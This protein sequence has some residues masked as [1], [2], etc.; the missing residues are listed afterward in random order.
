MYGLI[1]LKHH[2]IGKQGRHL[3]FSFQGKAKTQNDD[4]YTS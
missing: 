3:H 4:N 2:I 1:T